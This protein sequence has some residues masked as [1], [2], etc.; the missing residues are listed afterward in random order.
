MELATDQ[1][2]YQERSFRIWSF[3]LLRC[4][5]LGSVLLSLILMTVEGA[6]SVVTIFRRINS[7]ALCLDD[8][9]DE[10]PPFN[11]SVLAVQTDGT[12]E[13]PTSSSNLTIAALKFS[14]N[15]I[16]KLHLKKQNHYQN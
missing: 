14:R 16:Q 7:Y 12:R 5:I 10:V 9:E 6:N 1:R 8:F 13:V 2:K 15:F 11:S 3:P 4:V